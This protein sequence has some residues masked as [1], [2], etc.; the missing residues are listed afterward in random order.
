MTVQMGHTQADGAEKMVANKC[1]LCYGNAAG[2]ACVRVCPTEALTLVTE[3]ELESAMEKKRAAA[4]GKAY[5]EIHS[6]EQEDLG[7]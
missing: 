5:Q 6:Q 1:D 7:K 4:A 3:T 2:P